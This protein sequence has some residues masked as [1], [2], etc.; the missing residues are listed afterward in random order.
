MTWKHPW[1][2]PVLGAHTQCP[3]CVDVVGVFLRGGVTEL[4]EGELSR[5]GAA[6]AVPRATG[7]GNRPGLRAMS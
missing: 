5:F 3:L 4:L 6:A 2:Q 7:V 1:H